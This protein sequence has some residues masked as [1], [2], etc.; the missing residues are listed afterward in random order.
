MPVRCDV[1]GN[2]EARL[3]IKNGWT[4]RKREEDSNRDDA[5]V[6]RYTCTKCGRTTRGN[7][8]GLPEYDEE[9]KRTAIIESPDP[10][11]PDSNIIVQQQQPPIAQEEKKRE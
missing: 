8:F 3:I 1:C 10:V 9:P 7:N 2:T 5:K 11:G 6:R 4:Y